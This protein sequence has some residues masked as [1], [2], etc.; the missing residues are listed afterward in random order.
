MQI[1]T[2]GQQTHN[3]DIIRGS[4]MNQNNRYMYAASLWSYYTDNL[5]IVTYSD[6]KVTF[7]TCSILIFNHR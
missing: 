2:D 7:S 4:C 3:A 1:S 6:V 5:G